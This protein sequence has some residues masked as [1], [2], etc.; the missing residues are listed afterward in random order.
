MI[1]TTM[2]RQ[3][4]SLNS[5][6]LI[7]EHPIKLGHAARAQDEMI[8]KLEFGRFPRTRRKMSSGEKFEPQNFRRFRLLMKL[9]GDDF[10]FWQV[11]RLKPIERPLKALKRSKKI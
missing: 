6:S 7:N 5:F 2:K 11:G 10:N 8:L 4:Y 3:G 9:C 1:K